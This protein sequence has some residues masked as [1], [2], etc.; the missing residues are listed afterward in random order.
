LGSFNVIIY[1]KSALCLRTTHHAVGTV[2]TRTKRLG[3][4]LTLCI[5][6]ISMFRHRGTNITSFSRCLIVLQIFHRNAPFL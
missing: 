5:D 6:P 3:I 1:G 4:A 2:R